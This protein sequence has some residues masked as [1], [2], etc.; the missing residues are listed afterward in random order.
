VGYVHR[1]PAIDVQSTIWLD[2]DVFALC[3]KVFLVNVD[4]PLS[5]WFLRI[6]SVSI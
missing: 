4:K 3:F 5:N 2:E 1:Y 6:V